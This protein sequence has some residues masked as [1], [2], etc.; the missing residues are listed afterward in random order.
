MIKLQVKDYC[1]NCPKFVPAS[2]QC[3][4]FAD[5]K[6]VIIETVVYCENQLVCEQ[7]YR[8]IKKEYLE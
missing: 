5:N 7:M 1:Q 4:Y 6:S 3:E 2:S 8:R